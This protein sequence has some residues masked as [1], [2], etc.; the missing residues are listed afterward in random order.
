[1]EVI[2][3]SQSTVVEVFS[4]NTLIPKK[5][6]YCGPL[7]VLK[8]P[9]V[10]VVGA[11]EVQSWVLEWMEN[12]LGPALRNLGVGVV[13][14]GARGVD[15]M[16]HRLAMRNKLPNV[17]VIPSGLES[18]YPSSIRGWRGQELT[19][20]LSEYESF[21]EI[22]KFHFSSRNKIV[23]SLSPLT[24]VI[25]AKER[26]GTM[27]SSRL[28]L[29]AGKTLATVPG[30]PMDSAFGG[31][32]QLLFEGAHMLRNRRDIEALLTTHLNV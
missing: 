15:Q 13:S 5:L 19:L 12:E 1:M 14:G 2:K 30:S 28:A 20:F 10:A 21:Q 32:N 9:L 4:G 8:T 26:S 6:Y 16:A 25:Q 3:E 11:R 29:E 24:L 18:I 27:M 23:I 22:R 31:N 17:V 7:E